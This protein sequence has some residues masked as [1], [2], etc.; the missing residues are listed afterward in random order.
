M[1]CER[2]LILDL[3]QPQKNELILDAGCGTGIFTRTVIDHGS[4]VVGLDLSVPMLQYA[5]GAL[6]APGFT[7]VAADMLALPFTD[8]QFDKTLSVTALEFIEDAGTAI[9]ELFRI[10]RPKGCMVIATLNSL[11]PWAERRRIEARAKDHSVFK[12]AYF[13]SPDQLSV[14]AP[15]E[16]MI[17]TA[18]HFA[19]DADPSEARKIETDGQK[20]G[21][22]TGAFV[23]GRWRKQ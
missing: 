10:T 8:N 15:V 13:R 3:L 14:L 1:Q 4:Q 19:N 12:G 23:I 7:P 9:D 16:G 22:Q 21:A 5:C 17:K 11:S 20:A 6:P 18:I 2:T